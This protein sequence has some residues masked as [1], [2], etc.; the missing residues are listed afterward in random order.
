MKRLMVVSFTT[1]VFFSTLS[2]HA[3]YSERRVA[4]VIG[5]GNYAASPLK[6]PVNDAHDIAGA[7]RDLGFDVI[8]TPFR[9][10]TLLF[11]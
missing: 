10:S 7:L 6:N 8:V 1:L 2:A 5:N 9:A 4:L 11:A 3:R